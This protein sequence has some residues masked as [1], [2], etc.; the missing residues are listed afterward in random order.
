MQFRKVLIKELGQVITGTTPSTAITENFGKGYPFIKPSDLDENT[1]RVL[2]TEIELSQ[3]GYSSQAK[4]L[5]PRNTTCVVCIGTIGKLG[6]TSR[7]CFTNQQINS[8]IPDERV[9]DSIFVFYLLKY[10]IPQIQKLNAGSASGREN[11]N[12]STFENLE[13]EIPP[14]PTQHRIAAL[15]STYDDLIENNQRRIA[16]LEEMARSLYREWFVEFRFP[17][18]EKTS[19]T[20]TDQG[21]IPEGWS[22]VPYSALIASSTGGD[23]GA[24]VLNDDEN[25]AVT[26]I[27][28]TDFNEV[29]NGGAIRAPTRYIS[30]ASLG[31][32]KLEA[33]DIVI[34][35]SVNASSRCTGRALLISDGVLRRIDSNAICASFCKVFKP[36]NRSLTPLLYLHLRYLYDTGR[37][38]FFQNVA[39]NGIGN[40]QAKRFL[41]EQ[42][43]LLP[44][45]CRLLEQLLSILQPLVTTIHADKIDNLRR[46]RDLLLPRL[47]SGEL[48]V[49]ELEIAGLEETVVDA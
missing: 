46:T 32:R 19:F 27:R 40:F 20:E 17:G 15:L 5:L 8:V 36:K 28:G 31:K 41:D 42:T 44:N 9:S 34:E 30:R 47:M 2:S 23:W 37:M 25:C 14:L 12:K 39:A 35:N 1:F 38:A 16:I 6:L 7:P 43:I 13:V 4:K 3:T 21:R 49:S 11:V 48:D 24:E 45:D 29:M 22:F 18:Y 33:G 10:T 26:I